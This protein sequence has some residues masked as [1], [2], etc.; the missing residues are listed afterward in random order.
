MILL[1][2]KIAIEE[3]TTDRR[4]ARYM[5]SLKNNRWVCETGAVIFL[6]YYFRLYI[7][8]RMQSVQD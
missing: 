3:G 6:C 1:S 4:L 5:I 7:Q 2:G 8:A